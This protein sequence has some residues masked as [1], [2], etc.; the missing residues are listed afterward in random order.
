MLNKSVSPKNPSLHRI[1]M[2]SGLK[3]FAKKV[4]P[5]N[6]FDKIKE[7]Q[8]KD[9]KEVLAPEERKYLINLYRDDIREL[10]GLLERDLSNWLK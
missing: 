10:E 7:G 1:V 3:D 2:Q 6:F 5:K 4:L 9:E 8:Y